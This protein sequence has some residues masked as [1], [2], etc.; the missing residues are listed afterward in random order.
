MKILIVS[1][2][3]PEL[4]P[5]GAQQIAYEVFAG[6]RETPGVRPVFLASVDSSYP[7]LF[8]PGACIVGFDG[9][10]DEY[11]FLSRGYDAWWNRATEPRLVEAFAAFLHE[12]APDVVHFH[13][14][15]TYGVELL[16]LTRRVRPQARIV[17]TFHEFL[18]ICAADGH[19]LRRADRTL[20]D[21]ASPLRCHQCFP[22]QPPE[23]FFL[24]ARWMQAHLAAVDAFTVPSAFMR[25][26][27]A[28]WGLPEGKIAHVPNAQRHLA[29]AALPP[30]APGKRNRFG[31][32]GQL[33]DIKGVWLLLESVRLLRA[34]GFVDFTVEINGGN[35]QY[36]SAARR[37]EIEQ[38]MAEEAALPPGERIVTFNGA[39][40]QAQIASRMTRVDWVVAPSVWRESFA[41]VVGEAWMFARPVIAA[42]AGGPAERIG[43]G[44]AG[45]G[46]GG[47]L[48]E[49]GDARALA[50]ALRRAAS[51]PGLWE[52]LRASIPP[53]PPPAAM[54]AGYLAAYRG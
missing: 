53:L 43:G 49:R 8:K 39:Y 30:P 41:L 21:R 50:R 26:Y 15:L 3:H 18:A 22:E 44:A 5:G 6:L 2:F 31:F 52:R 28:A 23:Q 19:M 13:H 17:F 27:F 40:A 14:F 38:A 29:P 46:E 42:N 45:E 54:V 25:G 11:L 48:F 16:T 33:V 34:E 35:L 20:C 7:A 47:L 10:A 24:R 32:F 4:I 9:R 51:E 36:A 1:V 37:A 12:I